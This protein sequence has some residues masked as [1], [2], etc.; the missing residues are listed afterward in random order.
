MTR[1]FRNGF[2][3]RPACSALA[4]G[5]CLAFGLRAG[6]IRADAGAPKEPAQD[7][8]VGAALQALA[9]SGPTDPQIEQLVRLCEK[10]LHTYD[11]INDYESTFLKRE[12][13]KGKLGPEERI[14]LKFEKPFKI[15]MGWTNTRKKGLQVAYERG[16]HGG[17]LAVHQ[18]GLFFGLAAVVF[19]DRNSPWV[20][21]GSASYD[22]EDAGL[23]KFT[24]DFAAMVGKAAREKKLAVTFL[25]ER[26]AGKGPMADVRFPGSTPDDIYFAARVVVGFDPET[27]LPVFQ[28]L[29]DWK[30]QLIGTYAYRDLRLN[31]VGRETPFTK[32]ADGQLRKVYENKQRPAGTV[33]TVGRTKHSG[34][35]AP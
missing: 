26:P 4:V 32:I 16:A 35:L 6:P 9:Q 7:Q 27:A 3:R 21:E 34:P 22:I 13:D 10:S 20:R 25:K 29:Y 19:L 28:Q 30:G 31:V 17:K 8:A 14:F 18:P 24:A 1:F 15:F 23:G 33:P 5:L 12:T 11:G 2:T